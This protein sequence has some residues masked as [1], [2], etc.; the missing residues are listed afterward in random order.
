MKK[1][2]LLLVL[3]I[4]ILPGIVEAQRYKQRWKSYRSELHFGI[5]PSNFLGELGGAD[6]VGTNYFKDLEFGQTRLAV[7][8]GLRY[9]LSQVFALNTKLSY[10]KVSGS[11]DLT[12]E[13]FRNYRNLD[14][15]TNIWEASTNLEFAFIR[16]QVGH[17]YRLKGVRGQRGFEISAYGFDG[18][19]V[20]YFN[21]KGSLGSEYVSLQSLGTEGQGISSTRKK[22]SKVQLAI[23]MGIGFKY[24][25]DRRWGVGLEYGIRKTF[26]DYIDDASKTYYDNNE[27]LSFN[28]AVAA[29]MADKSD[30][31]FPYIT[32]AG[33]QRGDPRD[34]DAY[35]FAIISINYKIRTG[36]SAF[37]MF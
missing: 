33:Q 35:M 32:A 23:P 17:R 2:Y 5:G 10:G 31:E 6:Q 36:R 28:G 14:F 21:P 9:K 12:K 8:A 1:S 16:E 30:Q 24:A 13:F 22:Y 29:A 27:I 15:K 7:A 37:P 19:G 11:D 26:T 18:V 20:F 34:K 3:S 25:I 4:L